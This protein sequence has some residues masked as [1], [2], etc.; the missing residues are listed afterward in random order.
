MSQKITPNDIQAS[1]KKFLDKPS[2]IIVNA[3]QDVVNANKDY[4]QSIGYIV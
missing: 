4:L 1:S 3:N 2:I